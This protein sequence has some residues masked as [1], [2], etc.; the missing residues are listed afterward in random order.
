[1]VS[2]GNV[3]LTLDGKD[4]A[5]QRSGYI[6]PSGQ[7]TKGN[8]TLKLVVTDEGGNTNQAIVIFTIK[9]TTGSAAWNA[10]MVPIALIALA[11]FT[12]IK[13]TKK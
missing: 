10:M 2:E 13:R 5:E 8:H 12:K 9:L 11:I 7:L 3:K 4:L 1:M 6:L